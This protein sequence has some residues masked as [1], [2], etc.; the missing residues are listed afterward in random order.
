MDNG[1]TLTRISPL[2]ATGHGPR[3][4][5]Y[6]IRQNQVTYKTGFF[7]NVCA[8]ASPTALEEV[9][10][11]LKIDER[12]LRHL[13]IKKSFRDAVQPIPDINQAPPTDSG[14]DPS[15]PEYALRK[16]MSEY[17]REFP[18]GDLNRT[19]AERANT[20]ETP[21]D[22]SGPSGAAVENVLA[23]LKASSQEMRRKEKPGLA[24]LSN[25]KDETDPPHS[26]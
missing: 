13:A 15:D 26:S 4:L 17:E 14:L 1:A 7:V 10:R 24:W 18:G 22:R 20:S 3:D 9:N 16:F 19:K 25:L 2:G 12:V 5:A 11:Q 8:F 23:S 6:S 21:K